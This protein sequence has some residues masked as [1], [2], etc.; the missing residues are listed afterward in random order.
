MDELV[1]GPNQEAAE[2]SRRRAASQGMAESWEENRSSQTVASCSS[3]LLAVQACDVG[4]RRLKGSD[5]VH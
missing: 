2:R 3:I 5:A 1:W 4:E